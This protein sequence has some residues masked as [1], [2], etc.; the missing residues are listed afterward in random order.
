MIASHG[1]LQVGGRI[2]HL[3]LE[4]EHALRPA[5]E[6]GERPVRRDLLQRFGEVEIVGELGAFLALR[7]DHGRNHPAVVGDIAAQAADQLGILAEP[8]DQD[9]ARTFQRRLDVGHALFQIDEGD[10]RRFRSHDGVFQKPQRQRLQTGLAGDHRLG[11]A[12]GLVGQVKV[13]KPGLGV[14]RVKL[15]LQLVRQ[16]ALFGDAGQD[17]GAPLLKLPEI[18]QALFQ[19]AELGVVQAT[20]GFLAVPR[21]ER[22]R[23]SLI[24]QG[25]GCLDLVFPGGEFVGDTF[26]DADH[27]VKARLQ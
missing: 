14:G 24:Q 20:G 17:G 6:H 23:R 7:L 15:R 21:D 10:R 1:M 25:N 8:L 9:M 26:A 19:G 27:V 16:L 22:N 2:A 12:L 11:A 5:A 18:A 4:V 3:D 13:F